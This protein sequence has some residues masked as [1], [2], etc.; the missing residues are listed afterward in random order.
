M[1]PAQTH[2]KLLE[3]AGQDGSRDAQD[4]VVDAGD[5]KGLDPLHDDLRSV[6]FTRKPANESHI[7]GGHVQKVIR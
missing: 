1:I 5:D 4:A 6:V 2:V 7:K 3:D